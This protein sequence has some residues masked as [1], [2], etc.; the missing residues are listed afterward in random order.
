MALLISRTF[1]R[2][3]INEQYT[4]YDSELPVDFYTRFGDS[5]S[6]FAAIDYLRLRTDFLPD[7]DSDGL[8][9]F[10][11]DLNNYRA[12]SADSDSDSL[13]RFSNADTPDPRTF[14]IQLTERKQELLFLKEGDF[15]RAMRLDGTLT[16]VEG[17]DTYYDF[18]A[19]E[20]KW[21]QINTLRQDSE[22]WRVTGLASAVQT[23]SPDK[24]YF[25][26][27]NGEVEEDIYSKV[28]TPLNETA[29]DGEGIWFRTY[30]PE[31]NRNIF[32]IVTVEQDIIDA[33]NNNESR[34]DPRVNRKYR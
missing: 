29:F 33:R 22:G 14:K 34:L 2:D 20:R 1:F 32:D 31:L 30:V 26:M 7:S 27:T 18:D 6:A 28:K 23:H 5:D 8:Y 13:Q 17:M 3:P 16:W 4:V 10:D 9:V 25:R 11:S 24:R 21:N 15:Q 19:Y 12:W